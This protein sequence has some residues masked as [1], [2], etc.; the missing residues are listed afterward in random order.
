[1]TQFLFCML[2]LISS[3]LNDTIFYLTLKGI[4]WKIG[5]TYMAGANVFNVMRCVR[6]YIMVYYIMV[7]YIMV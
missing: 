1:M 2:N 3:Y 6:Y 4:I 7:F 5:V